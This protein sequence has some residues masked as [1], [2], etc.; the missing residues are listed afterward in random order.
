[1]ETVG[2]TQPPTSILLRLLLSSYDRPLTVS[3]VQESASFRRHIPSRCSM[4]Y[5]KRFLLEAKGK[6]PLRHILLIAKCKPLLSPELI[7]IDLDS[8]VIHLSEVTSEWL[9]AMRGLKAILDQIFSNPLICVTFPKNFLSILHRCIHFGTVLSEIL[10]APLMKDSHRFFLSH[11]INIIKGYLQALESKREIGY[12]EVEEM[13][14]RTN[15]MDLALARFQSQLI[16]HFRNQSYIFIEHYSTNFLKISLTH[17][18]N[19]MKEDARIIFNFDNAEEAKEFSSS[20]YSSSPSQ[21]ENIF[22]QLNLEYF[23]HPELFH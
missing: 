22:I 20:F 4:M 19:L 11:M 6:V 1:M 23:H 9:R 3:Y 15:S 8:R 10:P 2:L 13:G 16:N 21:E 17:R 14:I 12:L 7:D 5:L 18:K